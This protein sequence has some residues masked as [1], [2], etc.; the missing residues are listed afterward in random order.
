MAKA[1]PLLQHVATMMLP[2]VCHD[3]IWPGGA[4][5][6]RT[7]D[8]LLAKQVL[9]QL[10]YSPADGTRLPSRT[11]RDPGVVAAVQIGIRCPRPTDPGLASLDSGS[12]PDGTHLGKQ[13]IVPGSTLAPRSR[14][15]AMQGDVD[16]AST[17]TTRC[18]RSAG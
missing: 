12:T 4:S 16:K 14:A 9:F 3:G 11:F 1:D 13:T 2:Q 5:E 18:V 17:Q 15:M 6:T 7:R 8:P 10:S